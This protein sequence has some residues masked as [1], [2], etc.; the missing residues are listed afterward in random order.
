MIVAINSNQVIAAA[1]IAT[2]F[3]GI[4]VYAIDKVTTFRANRKSQAAQFDCWIGN[5]V[6]FVRASARIGLKSELI[7]S[8]SSAHAIRNAM[9]CTVMDGADDWN[10]IIVGPMT[11]P[12]TER[13]AFFTVPLSE[14]LVPASKTELIAENE[15]LVNELF[16]MSVWFQDARG[17]EWHRNRRGKLK[18]EKRP[19]HTPL[20]T[21]L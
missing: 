7:C 19:N 21:D 15:N 8:N 9:I 18:L 1:A 3:F 14:R 4:V 20:A 12:P 10:P 16:I 5:P 2:F 13:G 6:Q 11:V 17:N